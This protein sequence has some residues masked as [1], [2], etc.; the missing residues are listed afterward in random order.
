MLDPRPSVAA[1]IRVSDP[2]DIRSRFLCLDKNERVD[3]W[4]E[5]HWREIVGQLSWGDVAQYPVLEPFR[6]RM[7]EWVGV[8]TDWLAITGGSDPAIRAV[9]EVFGR[10][11]AAVVMPRP[12]FAMYPVY[13]ALHE[14]RI[15]ELRYDDS[16]HLSA[17]TVVETL[18]TVRPRL[19]CLPNPNSPTGTLIPTEGMRAILVEASRHGTAVL[20]DE[21]YYYFS[22][23][24]CL[25]LVPEFDNLIITRTFSK[26]GGLAGV[27]LGFVISQ[28][29]NIDYLRRPKP[30][31]EISSI[32]LRFGDYVIAHDRILWDYARDANA[33]RD[34]LAAHLR[35]LHFE[36]FDSHANFLNAR[37]PSR[38]EP[39]AIGAA[40]RARN[41]LIKSGF[42]DRPL[43]NCIRVTTASP[44]VMRRFLD[45]LDEVWRELS[46]GNESS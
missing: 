14:M 45:V 13:A 39:R 4:P 18:R 26:A 41:V 12:T 40:L 20:V 27:R 34:V 1:V 28:S 32:A 15:H 10:E 44:P 38:V 7:A 30:M 2:P 11:G 8:P 21:A 5:E 6:A 19:L 17:E 3:P 33:G 29:R 43:T 37:V 23:A 16:I 24:T 46:G 36:P 22:P 9:F 25:P 42:S 35:S 31:Y